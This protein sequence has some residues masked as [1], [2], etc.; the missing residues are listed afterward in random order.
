MN[1]RTDDAVMTL[2]ADL[3][4]S[5]AELDAAFPPARRAAVIDR[6][7]RRSETAA[8][9]RFTSRRSA[10]RPV[11]GRTLALAALVGAAAVAA[12]AVGPGGSEPAPR[13]IP[14][15]LNELARTA[16]TSTGLPDPGAH[17]WLYRQERARETGP[18]NE[19]DGT[20]ETE[21][22]IV[23]LW[24]RSDGDQYRAET[25]PHF[26]QTFHFVPSGRRDF[27]A[28]G[29]R[30]LATLPSSPAAL[31]RYLRAH[32]S[33]D[34]TRTE[35]AFTAL[36][37]MLMSGVPTPAQRAVLIRTLGLLPG[38]RVMSTGRDPSGLPAVRVDHRGDGEL[39]SLY[40]DPAD[41]RLRGEAD[42]WTGHGHRYGTWTTVLQTAVVDRPPAGVVGHARR[43][44]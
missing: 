24:T 19:R 4:P 18:R 17:R 30:F 26:S 41:S 28:P 11:A 36:R 8:P 43:V 21:V 39:D 34:G 37:D 31:Y 44:G 14:A 25:G 13:A 6:A 9:P 3:R 12:I 38:V 22:S 20:P 16:S 42:L 1:T 29:R 5:G 23:R 2:V 35:A 15:A 10:G 33:G 32:A 7:R 27:A 40:F